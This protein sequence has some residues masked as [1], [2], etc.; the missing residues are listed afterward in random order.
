MNSTSIKF[1]ALCSITTLRALNEPQK[2]IISLLGN[3]RDMEGSTSIG[4]LL[5]RLQDANIETNEAELVS[6]LEQAT[7]FKANDKES[8]T[9]QRVSN[10]ELRYKLF[11]FNIDNPGLNDHPLLNKLTG[12]T[13]EQK[14]KFGDLARRISD[15]LTVHA[16]LNVRVLMDA[17]QT[18]LQAGIDYLTIQFQMK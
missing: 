11:A 10:I 2:R 18:Y 14:S 17:E 15:I 7:S 3:S 1:S 9:A 12:F 4:D 16:K 8:L 13:P 6:Y 5:K